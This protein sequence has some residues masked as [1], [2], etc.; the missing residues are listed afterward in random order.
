MFGILST[1]KG[2]LSRNRN[3][4]KEYTSGLF[5][6][7]SSTHAY[8]WYIFGNSYIV[9]IRIN[10]ASLSCCAGERI[11]ITVQDILCQKGTIG[12]IHSIKAHISLIIHAIC[13]G[14]TVV[15]KKPRISG[16]PSNTQQILIKL[17]V[18][19]GPEVIKIFSCSTQLSM[20]FVLL[21]KITNNCRLLLHVAEREISLLINLKMP[22]IV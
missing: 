7:P 19:T 9:S 2:P 22:T 20:E 8:T 4:R 6:N 3:W 11:R 16:Y 15:L 13:S 10:T 14:F 5:N 1:G 17:D 18:Q 21:I 12:N